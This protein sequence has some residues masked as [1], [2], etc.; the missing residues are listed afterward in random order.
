MTTQRWR[1]RRDREPDRRELREIAESPHNRRLNAELMR[2][3]R[4]KKRRR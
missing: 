4:R 1:S 3:L 2:A